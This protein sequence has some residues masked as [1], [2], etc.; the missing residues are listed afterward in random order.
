MVQRN[1]QFRR[2]YVEIM[3]L[4]IIDAIY[5]ACDKI[6]KYP[7]QNRLYACSKTSFVPTLNKPLLNRLCA[8]SK[9]G[10]V[11]S[12]NLLHQNRLCTYA[13]PAAP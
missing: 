7:L 11:P 6:M 3:L 4:E 9:T 12:L 1:S 10:F 13:K 2:D 5:A 8:C